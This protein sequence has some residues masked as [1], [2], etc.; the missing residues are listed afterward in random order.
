M[1][2]LCRDRFGE[3]PL[4]YQERSDGVIFASDMRAVAD[5]AGQRFTID[6]LSV[7]RFLRL[8]VLE[9]DERTLIQEIAQVPAATYLPIAIE[10]GR[11]RV[12]SPVRYWRCPVEP[13]ANVSPCDFENRLRAL[14]MDSMRIRL[15][16]DV[17]V[18][19]L[20]SG[21]LDSSVMATTAAKLGIG[22]V[23][24]LSLIDYEKPDGDP[25]HIEM[26]ERYLG[27]R[28]T[29]VSLQGTGG[30]PFDQL[31][32]TVRRMGTPINSMAMV[33]HFMLMDRA[34]QSGVKVVLS[35]QGA[36]EALCGYRKFLGFATQELLRSGRVLEAAKLASGFALNATVLTQF[37]LPEGARYLPRMG[38]PD[39]RLGEALSDISVENPRLLVNET[40]IERQV[41]DL[42][43]LSVP[44]LNQLEDRSSMANSCEVRLPFLDH[45]II[46][47]S[48][49]APLSCKLCGG[50]TK[51]GL[52]RAYSSALPHEVTW[53]RDKQGFSN[54]E[55]TLLKTVLR[56]R[57]ENDYLDSKRNVFEMGLLNHNYAIQSL[58]RL[59]APV[60]I[61]RP[62]VRDFVQ[63][64]TLE[65]WLEDHLEYL[66]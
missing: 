1:A 27:A 18:G 61:R 32:E 11:P 45:R 17:P 42:T 22:N 56:T 33:A 16:S 51:V 35:G 65:M 30:D 8:G 26:M 53:R 60:S 58:K 6:R 41:R 54:P 13:V 49:P 66:R 5:L 23:L 9:L 55:A 21:G 10:S 37:S 25:K 34:R 28:V 47:L 14:V 63:M 31:R 3:K 57:L 64:M 24:L 36:D 48:V 38:R 29:R 44:T 62:W 12:L 4:H 59:T 2:Y 50:W 52:R 43:A 39:E 46:E 7:A 15:R 20:L 40:L 19:I